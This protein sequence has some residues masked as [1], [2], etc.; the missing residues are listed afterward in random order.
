MG[1]SRK[2]IEAQTSDR[3]R[4]VIDERKQSETFVDQNF[5]DGF[6][7]VPDDLANADAVKVW[8]D[9]VE[10]LRD[11]G[12]YGNVTIPELIGYC[13]AWAMNLKTQRKLKKCSLEQA[14]KYA[15]TIKKYSEEM[16]R[17]MNRG[18]FSVNARL[19]YAET[20]LKGEMEDINNE[21]GI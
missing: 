19:S 2:P 9:W 1:R 10:Y 12:F 3:T 6:D 16:T 5:K 13:N 4:R 17:C 14:D 8:K 7:E 21:F 20:K 18:G 15:G 11:I